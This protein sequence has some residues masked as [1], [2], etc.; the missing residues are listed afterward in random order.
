MIADMDSHDSV[1]TD[2]K[3]CTCPG[4]MAKVSEIK[5]KLD[6]EVMTCALVDL[7]VLCLLLNFWRKVGSS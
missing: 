3:A 5:F 7:P 6:F 1:S 4:K 2:R